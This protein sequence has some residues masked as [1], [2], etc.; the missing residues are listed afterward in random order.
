MIK[1]KKANILFCVFFYISFIIAGVFIFY[2]Y[3]GIDTN[4]DDFLSMFLMMVSLIM[5]VI[6]S[7]FPMLDLLEKYSKK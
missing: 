4:S 5:F 3:W 1:N 6:A 7:I 2:N